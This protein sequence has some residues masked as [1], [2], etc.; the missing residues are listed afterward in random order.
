ME[1]NETRNETATL[2]YGTSKS[3]MP[4]SSEM[5]TTHLPFEEP[6]LISIW[7]AIAGSALGLAI[8]LGNVVVI[9]LF[10]RVRSLRKLSNLFILNLAVSDLLVGLMSTTVFTMYNVI[11]KWPFSRLVCDI[12][13]TIDYTVCSVSLFA[14]L[15][16]TVDRY[17]ALVDPIRHLTRINKRQVWTTICLTWIVAF[18]I[19]GLPNF[20]W[21]RFQ[22]EY[23]TSEEECVI[24][25]LDV[26]W[27]I[28]LQTILGYWIPL[29]VVFALYI[30]IYQVATKTAHKRVSRI[31]NAGA[32]STNP[33]CKAHEHRTFK[34]VENR[35]EPNKE[36]P[37]CT[38]LNNASSSEIGVMNPAFSKDGDIF[39]T[40]RPQDS[41]I[42]PFD[43]SGDLNDK[44]CCTTD[45][46]VKNQF[47]VFSE[48]DRSGFAT[49]IDDA[50]S[51]NKVTPSKEA[52]DTV[53]L[54]GRSESITTLNYPDH[55]FELD[56]MQTGRREDKMSAA[57]VGQ[58]KTVV[59]TAHNMAKR[60]TKTNE[61][62]T[63]RT[64]T[65]L[66]AA[67][68]CCWMPYHIVAIVI[69]LCPKCI[70]PDVFK[71]VYWMYFTNSAIN[72]VCYALANP[73][74]RKA[75]KKL[76]FERK[77]A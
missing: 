6:P 68:V 52:S 16:I 3:P 54:H 77:L 11:G 28:I 67:I 1:L 13:L 65:T 7:T 42:V 50:I 62:K 21:P 22:R 66:L 26:T 34:G 72:P 23:S 64:V 12:W 41:T 32:Q 53:E 2:N 37:D 38:D 43:G 5:L 15:A 49:H 29:F 24:A 17:I 27:F 25:Y 19:Y 69:T 74:M 14:I 31:D 36:L 51:A 35:T 59:N 18:V 63:F 48:Q 76:I 58:S 30:K 46:A 56:D 20:L 57:Y 71:V 4:W 40:G 75:L 39:E 8:I 44:Q 73:M 45:D 60:T 9:L 33:T 55:V 10:T 61:S 47:H 70:H